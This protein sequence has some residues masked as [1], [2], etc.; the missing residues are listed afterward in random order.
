MVFPS[1]PQ[2]QKSTIV[3]ETPSSDDEDDMREVI[4]IDKTSGESVK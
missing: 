3:L 4:V 2:D 1:R